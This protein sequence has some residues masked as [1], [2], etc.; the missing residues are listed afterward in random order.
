MSNLLLRD[1]A[2]PYIAP[3]FASLFWSGRPAIPWEIA[4]IINIVLAEHNIQSIG[5]TGSLHPSIAAAIGYGAPDR[6]INAFA[7]KSA[8][9]DGI[10]WNNVIDDS[11]GMEDTHPA[12]NQYLPSHLLLWD[13][14]TPFFR[15]EAIFADLPFSHSLVGLDLKHLDTRE[16][17]LMLLGF[18][19]EH[20][21]PHDLM[22]WLDD[23]HY[24]LV[25][26][27]G[28]THVPE[29]PGSLAYRLVV[30]TR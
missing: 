25:D 21:G 5:V 1:K 20:E 19:A 17:R 9:D 11:P 2:R 7:F 28:N 3:Q 14:A 6:H 26:Y 10:G 12:A 29:G 13:G 18:M 15:S 23:H 27:H 30:A 4:D 16:Y 24:L 22:K 8:W